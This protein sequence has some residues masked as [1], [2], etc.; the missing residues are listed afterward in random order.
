MKKVNE[1]GEPLTLQ[2]SKQLR[3]RLGNHAK[4]SCPFAST[5]ECPFGNTCAVT[6][7]TERIAS[8]TCLYFVKELLPQDKELER[9]YHDALP[10]SHPMKKPQELMPK[11]SPQ[12]AARE[13][14]GNRSC[15]RCGNSYAPTGTRQERCKDCAAIA[16]RESDKK[17]MADKRLNDALNSSHL[18]P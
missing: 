3:K 8:N 6:I 14:L 7:Q 18:N 1:H 13:A 2:E 4:A 11:R 5:I 10:A 17:R 15:K 9:E 12:E 16:K